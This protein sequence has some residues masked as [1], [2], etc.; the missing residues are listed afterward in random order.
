MEYL[1]QDD[2]NTDP[3]PVRMNKGKK[4]F[5][6]GL[7]L[8]CFIAI[9]VAGQDLRWEDSV[10]SLVFRPAFPRIAGR[11][12]FSSEFDYSLSLS[13]YSCVNG[14]GDKPAGQLV[15][16]QNLKYGFSVSSLRFHL[17]ND[18]IHALGLVYYID[19]ISQFQT[20]ENTL[21]TRISF[22][23]TKSIE[24]LASSILTTRIFNAW[25][26]TEGYGGS[27]VKTINSSFLTP[28]I[29]NFSAGFGINIRN[30][31]KLE[32][33]ISSAKLTY[34]MDRG[35]FDKTGRDSFYGVE[36]GYGSKL[37]YGLSL[38]LLLDRLIVRKIQWNCDLLLFKAGK[39]PVDMTLKNLFAY[40]INRFLKTSLQ[41]RLLYDED[42]SRRLRMENLL[43][44]GF[45]FHL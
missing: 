2:Q 1:R 45:D 11:F 27:V 40:R 29:C 5:V 43:S 14:Q 19:S 8:A 22:E 9:G 31:G 44:V 23:V 33:G 42:V 30:S 36:K 41:T 38:H 16:L 17:T 20:D 32:F 18:L 24:F 26:I 28:L 3:C 25:D 37:E 21:T 12:R 7:V 34:I 10:K 39:S 4:R 13:G 15:F 35:I 6:A